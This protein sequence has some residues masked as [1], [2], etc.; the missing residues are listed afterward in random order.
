MIFLLI[1]L[2]INTE[3][4]LAPFSCERRSRALTTVCATKRAHVHL[5]QVQIQRD[6]TRKSDWEK[7]P[8]SWDTDMPGICLVLT[9]N[10]QPGS[11]I[12]PV[13]NTNAK[14]PCT[15]NQI[16]IMYTW[17]DKREKL[18]NEFQKFPDTRP[19]I[20]PGSSG[21]TVL[22]GTTRTITPLWISKFQHPV[23]FSH[24]NMLT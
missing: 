4:I 5:L 9:S 19:G 20:E 6:L 7:A 24:L 10:K 22:C 11:F 3:F 15:F 2:W 17:L 14:L 12:C 18:R 8:R 21:L 1:Y 16:L 13:Y 23:N